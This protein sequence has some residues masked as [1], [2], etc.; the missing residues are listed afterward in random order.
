MTEPNP[1]RHLS[2]GVRVGGEVTARQSGRARRFLIVASLSLSVV[3]WLSFPILF[4]IARRF[5]AA[6]ASSDSE[7]GAMVWALIGAF[8]SGGFLMIQ[9]VALILGGF[10]YRMRHAVKAGNRG[11]IHASWAVPLVS[12]VLH[13]LVD[14]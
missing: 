13:I 5:E 1:P 10:V 8:S 11:W 7:G 14:Y 9:A 3:A 12:I 6:H 2:E 4:E